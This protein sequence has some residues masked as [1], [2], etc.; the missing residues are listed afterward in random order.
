M[1]QRFAGTVGGLGFKGDKTHTA[2]ADIGGDASLGDNA[3][4][5]LWMANPRELLLG[6]EQPHEIHRCSVI[7]KELRRRYTQGIDCRE[8]RRHAVRRVSAYRPGKLRGSVCVNLK[9]DR[10]VRSPCGGRN[11]AGL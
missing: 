7:T 8:G 10:R 4:A 11:P 5:R 9:S 2:A 3:L 1:A 6:M